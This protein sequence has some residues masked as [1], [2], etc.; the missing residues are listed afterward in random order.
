MQALSVKLPE[1]KAMQ[2][3]ACAELARIHRAKTVVCGH[4]HAFRDEK[5]A[6]GTRWIVLDAFGGARGVIDVG[7]SGEL[8]I[9]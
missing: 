8:S 3:D 7:E 4:A 9:R 1:E 5:L 6:D 2:A